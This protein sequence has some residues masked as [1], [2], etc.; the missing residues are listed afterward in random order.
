MV[1][2]MVVLGETQ[3]RLKAC[4]ATLLVLGAVAAFAQTETLGGRLTCSPNGARFALGQP[5]TPDL[6]E[7]ARQAAQAQTVRK[8]ELGGAYTMELSPRRL[9]IEVDQGGIVRDL[10]CG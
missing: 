1:S 6:A 9:N 5:F 7:R 3:A 2:E 8:I 4:F 10:K